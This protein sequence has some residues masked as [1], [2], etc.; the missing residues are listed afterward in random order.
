M[1]APL[2]R[3]LLWLLPWV[4]L[5]GLG[6]YAAYLC[7]ALGLG[8][9]YSGAVAILA[10]DVGQPLRFWFTFWHPNV[11]SMLTEVTFCPPARP[12]AARARTASTAVAA[13]STRASKR[14][15]ACR[16]PPTG[17]ST[18]ASTCPSTVSTTV[19]TRG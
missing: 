13:P 11:H 3:F 6:L 2:P 15:G 5:L 18:S 1:R 10:I 9:C 7:L 19:G 17:P 16:R 8:L 12:P 14:S 4:A